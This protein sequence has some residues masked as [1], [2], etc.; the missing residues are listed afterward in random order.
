MYRQDAAGAAEEA[1]EGFLTAATGRVG[2]IKTR[3]KGSRV[4]HFR[5]IKDALATGIV[6]RWIFERRR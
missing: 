2:V 5:R 6:R 4:A 3:G 1:R